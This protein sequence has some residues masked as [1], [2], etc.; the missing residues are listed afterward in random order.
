MVLIHSA[1]IAA[2]HPRH[3]VTALGKLLVLVYAIVVDMNPLVWIFRTVRKSLE[4][5]ITGVKKPIIQASIIVKERLLPQ[6]L[7]VPR[8][9]L[10]HLAGG[11]RLG[12]THSLL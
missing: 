9:L 10:D 11:L 8:V 5:A 1:K 7:P 6:V 12:R 3:R 4:Q 2:G